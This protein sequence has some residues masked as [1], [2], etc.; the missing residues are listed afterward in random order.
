MA[1]VLACGPPS[2][3][4]AQSM[5]Q[6]LSQISAPTLALS[7]YI[8]DCGARAL[9]AAVV[10]KAEYHILDTLAAMI[11][12]GR[13]LPGEKAIGFVTGLGGVREAS[14][15]GSR[16]VT[17]AINA[18]LAGGMLA[19]AD[20]TDD[21][22]A[23]SRTHPGCAVLPAALAAAEKTHA[24]GA[25]F[26][27]AVVL[28]YD[29]ASRIMLALGPDRFAAAS[30]A[31]HSFGGTFGAGAAAASLLGL[32][33]REVRHALSYCAQQASGVACNVRDSEHIEKAFDFG[34]M[35]ARNG[36]SAALMAAAGFTGVDD[37]FAGERNFLEAYG[38]APDADQ[39]AD[40][41]GARY[42]IMATNIK[43]WSVG[44]PAQGALDAVTHLMQGTSLA[45]E[46]IAHVAVHL[47]TRSARTVDDAPMP[48]V[49]VQHLVAML[50]IDGKL[51]FAS[52]HDHGRMQDPAIL[53]LKRRIAIVP[54]EE[55]MQAR[56]ARQAI[57][58]LTLE[59]GRVLSHRAVAVRGTA[60]NPMTR[61][62][63]EEKARDLIEPI[64]GRARMRRLI[65]ILRAVEEIED[66]SALR[67]LWRVGTP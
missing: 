17:S 11:S 19:H 44:S 6:P 43:K 13:L 25:R 63:V 36:V 55:L 66:M 38:V 34:G 48:D 54:S 3:D 53:A 18:A 41:L 62:E 28:G 64:L 15:P 12:G 40:G 32:D 10:E 26:L 20:E 2:S 42:E 5:I 33:P 47:P 35:P 7:A 21:S 29:V 8:A 67:P 31:T 37:V 50:L 59:D 61:R 9:P 49:N 23:P 46:S 56:P 58:V 24:D 4:D 57:V 65:E 52:I 30:R 14:V 1:L 45:P 27:R 16:I 51:S 22:H 39:L 60:D